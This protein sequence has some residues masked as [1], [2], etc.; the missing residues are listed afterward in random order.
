MSDDWKEYSKL[1]MANLE[2]HE[3]RI[4]VLE[5]ALAE[6]KLDM[7]RMMMKYSFLGSLAA[8]ALVAAPVLATWYF[9]K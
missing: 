2:D 8:T 9:G 3:E 1:V 6:L 4:K 5:Q 7:V